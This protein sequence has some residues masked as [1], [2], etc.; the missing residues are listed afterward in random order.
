MDPTSK[1]PAQV[2]IIAWHWKDDKPSSKLI[3]TQFTDAR[4]NVQF[5]P[6]VLYTKHVVNIVICQ[7]MGS[8][9]S[10]RELLSKESHLH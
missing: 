2:E 5:G 9:E 10:L 8:F 1:V 3:L 7:I 4:V 6:N